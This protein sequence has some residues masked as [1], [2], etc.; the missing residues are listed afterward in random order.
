MS[1]ASSHSVTFSLRLPG[2]N[3]RH[4]AIFLFEPEIL[5]VAETIRIVLRSRKANVTA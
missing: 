2:E 3:Y 4:N 5:A 1:K